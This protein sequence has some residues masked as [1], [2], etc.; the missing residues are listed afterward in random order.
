[1]H[2][3]QSPGHPVQPRLPRAVAFY[4]SLGFAETFKAIPS[5]S[6][7]RSTA[8]RS[9]SPPSPSTRDDHGLDPVPEGQRA[10]VVLW[11]DDA[12]A[13]FHRLTADGAPP[14]APPHEWLGRAPLDRLDLGSGREPDPDRA[15]PLAEPPSLHET[16]HHART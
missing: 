1:M 3:P 13:A 8:T 11:T 5:T 7:L 9:G 16:K 10:A 4:T 15:A 2:V 14:L 12:A 6:T